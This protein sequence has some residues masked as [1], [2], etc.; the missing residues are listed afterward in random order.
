[1]EERTG[2]YVIRRKII[3]TEDPRFPSGYR[4]ALHFGYRDGRG[5]ILRSDNENQTIGRHE[6]HTPDGIE[7]IEFPGMLAL[8]DRFMREIEDLP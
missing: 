7:A 8:R 2:G 6:R 1:M 4:D 3:R 5:T